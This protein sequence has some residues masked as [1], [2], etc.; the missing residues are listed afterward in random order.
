MPSIVPA[1]PVDETAYSIREEEKNFFK[2]AT[3]I[4][5]DEGLRK[6]ICEIQARAYSIFPYPCIRAFYFL[7]FQLCHY[8]IY[9]DI[10]KLGKE[11]PDAIYLEIGCAF[12]TDLRKLIADGYALEN[13]V[14]SDI[15]KDYYDLGHQLFR[16]TPETYPFPFIPGD[17]F[18]LTSELPEA[19]LNTGPSPPLRSLTSL[20]PLHSRVSVLHASSV[21]H[22]FPPEKQ[23]RL[24]HIFASLLS[25]SSGSIIVG[26]Q[27]STESGIKEWDF[28]NAVGYAWLYSV[29]AWKD[30]WMGD[31]GPFKPEE[32]D[33]QVSEAPLP[34]NV[35]NAAVGKSIPI[36]TFM[37]W[38][39]KRV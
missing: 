24:A 22:L 20:V 11:R 14:A 16:T 18:D 13:V 26:K 32:V 10:L 29:S 4:N 37:E 2:L 9:K 6:H 7:N 36:L 21:F 38:S 23:Q 3:G 39:L 31:N 28:G 27:M 25:P 15:E 12:G 33:A 34:V 30:L 1:P 5:D 8:Q 35:G 19:R 17:V